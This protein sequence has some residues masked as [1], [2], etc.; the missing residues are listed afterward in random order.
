MSNIYEYFKLKVLPELDVRGEDHLTKISADA[1][2]SIANNDIEK[3]HAQIVE[4][5]AETINLKDDLKK[6]SEFRLNIKPIVKDAVCLTLQIDELTALLRIR[7]EK[8]KKCEMLTSEADNL[9]S[10]IDCFTSLDDSKC[11]LQTG[12]ESI[13]FL[14]DSNAEAVIIEV[15]GQAVELLSAITDIFIIHGSISSFNEFIDILSRVLTR[16]KSEYMG[17]EDS[18]ND[19]INAIKE[20]INEILNK[21]PGICFE[22]IDQFCA[23]T[24]FKNAEVGRHEDKLRDIIVD[25]LTRHTVENEIS[26]SHDLRSSHNKKRSI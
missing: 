11:D 23:N 15:D 8:M 14:L 5:A 24:V 18:I 4:K 26:K 6:I 3:I 12:F 22:T 2:I 17:D 9:K 7:M 16:V 13:R 19:S 10:A 25:G 1:I 20:K 21:S